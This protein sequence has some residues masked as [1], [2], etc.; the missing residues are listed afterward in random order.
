MAKKNAVVPF[1]GPWK[2]AQLF[3][4]LKQK[5]AFAGIDFG[6]ASVTVFDEDIGLHVETCDMS[7]AEDEISL[8]MH[9]E[10]MQKEARKAFPDISYLQDSTMRTFV[11]RRQWITQKTPSVRYIV[12]KYPALTISSLVHQEFKAI[13]DVKLLGLKDEEDAAPESAKDD[14]ML[15]A[16]IYVL[17]SLVKER[18]EAFSHIHLEERL[19]Y[20]GRTVHHDT[21]EDSVG[22]LTSM[23]LTCIL[24]VVLFLFCIIYALAFVLSRESQKDATTVDITDYFAVPRA[25][26]SMVTPPQ[27]N[28]R[29]LVTNTAS[30]TQDPHYVAPTPSM[31]QS[32]CT[33][34]LCRLLVYQLM[35][36]LD[37]SVDPCKDFYKFVCNTF[38]GQNEFSHLQQNIKLTTI[39]ILSKAELP[40]SNQL[41]WQKAAAMYQACVSFASAAI[42]ETKYLIEWMQSLNLDFLNETRLASVNPVEMMVRGSLSIGVEAVVSIF[43]QKED[44]VP[45]KTVLQI[46][47]SEEQ[48]KWLAQNRTAEDYVP[49][50]TMYGARPPLDK[51]LATKIKGYETQLAAIAKATLATKG[52]VGHIRIS[53]LGEYTKPYV[54]GGP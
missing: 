22:W 38:R 20:K 15:T 49:L 40:E 13:T 54:T 35:S 3:E 28:H 1:V 9:V 51:L 10:A 11:D 5:R 12:E 19:L 7:D 21:E 26:P 41:S 30:T 8:L 24:A 50:L 53:W 43:H 48:K 4:Y 29:P 6:S 33:G 32:V 31:V 36:K 52:I 42:P 34:S 16:A 37:Y 45:K 46:D 47:Y 2:R 25:S 14:L 17:P 27:Q 23:T 44:F 39:T 18:M